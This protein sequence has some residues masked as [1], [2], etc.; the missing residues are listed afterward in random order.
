VIGV[1]YDEVVDGCGCWFVSVTFILF[2]AGDGGMTLE[3]WT[4]GC[5]YQVTFCQRM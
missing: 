2:L 4:L 3:K 5:N 1:V